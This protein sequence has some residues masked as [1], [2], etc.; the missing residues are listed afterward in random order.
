MDA[1]GYPRG[2]GKVCTAV[3]RLIFAAPVC[4]LLISDMGG[5]LGI[6]LPHNG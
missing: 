5:E 6:D 1:Q 3:L 4:R 2:R